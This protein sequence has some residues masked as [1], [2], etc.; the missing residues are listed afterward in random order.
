MAFKILLLN[1]T[2]LTKE[3]NEETFNYYLEEIMIKFWAKF[4]ELK[5][6]SKMAKQYKGI[7]EEQGGRDLFV[8]KYLIKFKEENKNLE[9]EQEE[10]IENIDKWIDL[11]VELE[12]QI[13][14]EKISR[15]YKNK[16][17]L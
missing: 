14:W 3:Y 16:K 17:I 5:P 13:K 4:I 1:M 15:G 9:M 7:L 11:L 2:I 12:K 10:I 8:K 6:Y